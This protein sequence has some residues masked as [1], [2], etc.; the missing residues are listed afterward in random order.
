MNRDFARWCGSAAVGERL[1][2]AD[3]LGD[4]LF[5]P[6]ASADERRHCT[7]ALLHLVGDASP[8]VRGRIAQRLAREAGAPRPLVRLLCEDTDTIAVPLACASRALLDDDLVDLSATGTIRLRC[9]IARRTSVSVAVSAALLLSGER[10]V[11]LELLANGGAE[12]APSGLRAIAEGPDGEDPA[13]RD[14]LL[15][16]AALPADIRHTLMLRTGEALARMDLARSV[17]GEAAARRIVADACEQASPMVAETLTG[18]RMGE[19]VGHLRATG[20]IT[21]AFLVRVACEGR[22]DLFATVL[23]QLSGLDARRVH[24]ILVEARDPSFAALCAAARVPHETVPVLSAGL[25]LWKAIA[26]EEIAVEGE[27]GPYVAERLAELVRAGHLTASPDLRSLLVRVS[28]QA[29]G[30]AL[31][32]ADR[33]KLAA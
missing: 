22:L 1:Q 10:V 19:F 16:R 29:A 14:L 5:D 25:R 20:R 33:M 23:A 18:P 9:A 4:A 8:K 28:A 13:V 11:T 17:L 26:R 31:R 12:I 27:A 2:A 24:A 21:A 3:L 7:D 6:Q 30:R 32:G 15:R